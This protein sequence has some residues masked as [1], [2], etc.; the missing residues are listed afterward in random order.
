LKKKPK[1]DT[2]GPQ[3]SPNTG[4]TGTSRPQKTAEFEWTIAVR[5]GRKKCKGT[6]RGKAGGPKTTNPRRLPPWQ[7]PPPK[8]GDSK[9]GGKGKGGAASQPRGQPTKPRPPK[10]AAILLSV[11]PA[12]ESSASVSL[13]D[14]VS[15]IRGSIKLS[16]FD[17]ASLKSKKV[18][19]GGIL[20][21]VP[22]QDSGAK[23]DKLAEAFKALLLPTRIVATPLEGF[24]NPAKNPLKFPYVFFHQKAP[25]C[26]FFTQIIN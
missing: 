2:V 12:K 4:P 8:K 11:E 25:E 16:E 5:K 1:S 3:A 22:G 23:A 7:A 19:A 26:S 17:I 14:A 10:Q 20:Y 24:M 21:E 6:E 9:S 13:G 15:G 18:A